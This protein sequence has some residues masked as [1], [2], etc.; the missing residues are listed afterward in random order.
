MKLTVVDLR[1]RLLSVSN[2]KPKLRQGQ[3]QQ[4][5]KSFELSSLSLSTPLSFEEQS[6]MQLKAARETERHWGGTVNKNKLE[7]SVNQ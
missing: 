4:Q 6:S 3:Q 2:I 7:L 5:H 1:S